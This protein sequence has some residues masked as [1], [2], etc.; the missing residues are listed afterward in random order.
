MA[1]PPPPWPPPWPG[2]AAT[3]VTALL[4]FATSVW[5]AARVGLFRRLLP[6]T[7]TAAAGGRRVEGP[8][9]LRSATVATDSG[10]PAPPGAPCPAPGYATVDVRLGVGGLITAVAAGG[11]LTPA[12]GEGVVDASR[13]LLTP[14]FV[15]AHT[16]STEMLVRGLLPPLPLDLGA[17]SGIRHGSGGGGGGVRGRPPP[18]V[19][20]HRRPV[21]GCHARGDGAAAVG[22]DERVGPRG[23][24]EC[25]RGRGRDRRVPGG[26]GAPLPGAHAQ[27]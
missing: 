12:P 11:S 3:L 21:A 5:V 8:W 18:A 23:P 22:G 13:H 20:N 26:G 6:A 24:A 16:H 15:N 7:A 10:S 19:V 14:G 4:L 27:R 2:A 1:P 17:P 25:G 9:L